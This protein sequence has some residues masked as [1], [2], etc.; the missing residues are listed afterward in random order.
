LLNV[1][2]PA[3]KSCL[4]G[5]V[6]WLL[7]ASHLLPPFLLLQSGWHVK[8]T[9][10]SVPYVATGSALWDLSTA[11]MIAD[12]VFYPEV[13]VI[14]QFADGTTD[15]CE[16]LQQQGYVALMGLCTACVV[17]AD[18]QP[19]LL[20][21][22]FASLAVHQRD[23]LPCAWLRPAGQCDRRNTGAATLTVESEVT[24]SITPSMRAAAIAVSAFSPLFLIVY[25]VSDSLYYKRTGKS[26]RLIH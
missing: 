11:T 23:A 22:S 20:H 16:F 18:G 7:S 13:C 19:L 12:A 2:G 5:H 14:C 24:G 17:H 15:Y 8:F 4:C 1:A 26:L 3:H 9:L 10:A 25:W 21:P 6:L